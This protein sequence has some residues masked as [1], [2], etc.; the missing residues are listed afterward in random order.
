[1]DVKTTINSIEKIL[2]KNNENIINNLLIF[3]EKKTIIS[4]ELKD[5]ILE[6][7]NSETIKKN[8]REP[9]IFNLFVKDESVIIK[10]NDKNILSREILKQ[11]SNL[12]KNSDKGIFI[13]KFTDTY[14][15][16]NK[17]V[18]KIEAYKIALEQW[19]KINHHIN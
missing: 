13:K 16:N 10:N 1:M 2:I 7:K 15:K 8:K 19:E 12:W 6:Y 3:L 11:A 5:Y 9:S 4:E 14:L 17:K 18:S